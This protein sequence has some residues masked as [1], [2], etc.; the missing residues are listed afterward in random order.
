MKEDER[1]MTDRDNALADL[2]REVG[3][4]AAGA[5][6]WQDIS[7][8]IDYG[9]FNPAPPDA[10]LR[11]VGRTK[12]QEERG[13]FGRWLVD[14]PEEGLRAGLIKAARLDRQ[15]PLDGG[16]DEVR[17]RL[18]ACAAD[19]DMFEACDEAELDWASY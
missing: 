18:H 2:R 1:T 8:P 19:G 4:I 15:F 6:V 9:A 16:P 12:T 7:K 14:Q 17:A 10:R 13:P 3:R 11:P 5:G